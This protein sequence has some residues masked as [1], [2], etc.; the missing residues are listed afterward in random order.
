MTTTVHK[1]CFL[2]NTRTIIVVILIDY[3]LKLADL[4]GVIAKF[5]ERIDIPEVELK[6]A[7]NP[8]TEPTMEVWL[9][10]LYVCRIFV[11]YVC[12]CV[13][14]WISSFLLVCVYVRLIIHKIKH[15]TIFS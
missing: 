5:F 8:Y 14:V 13:S 2:K 10:M 15:L 7:Y 6:P 11:V 12:V 4:I 9:C 1:H 3:D